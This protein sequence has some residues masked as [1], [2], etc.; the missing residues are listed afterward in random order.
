MRP[1]MFPVVRS[2]GEASGPVS[3]LEVYNGAFGTI[4][5]QGRHGA[6]MAMMSVDH[7]DVL[8]FVRAKEV[9]GT[10][11]NF[12]ISVKMTD[13]FMEKL[14]NH[15]DEPWMCT[16]EGKSVKPRRIL[17]HPNRTVHGVEEVDIT[18]GKLFDEIVEYAWHNGEPGI[19][20]IDEVNRT[21]P[22]P[23]FGDIL[24]SNPC[25]S[26]ET[27]VATKKGLVPI[28]ELARDDVLTDARVP[29]VVTSLAE[30]GSV[31]TAVKTIQGTRG[32]LARAARVWQTGVKPVYRLRTQS[33]Y[34]LV[35]TAD[36]K[37]VTTEGKVELSCL[38]RKHR[39]L[40]QSAEGPFSTARLLP[41][42]VTNEVTGENGRR[43]AYNFPREWSKELG[44]VMGWL[45]GDGWLRDAG[46]PYAAGFTFAEGD[47]RILE[48]LK[49]ILNGFY[50]SEM[51]EIKRPNGVYHL[52]Y[53]SRHFVEFFKALGVRAARSA[54]KRVPESL[55]AAP[56]ET[57]VG[58][59]QGLFSADGTVAND[60]KKGSRY[61]RLTAKSPELL[62]QVQLLLLNLGIKSKLY[63]RARAPREAFAYKSKGG[64]MRR[65]VS[66]GVLYE[67]QIS[68]SSLPIFLEKVG[69]LCGKFD[70][71]VQ[72]VER[73][74]FYREVFE[75][76]V[77]TIE[78]VGERD[79]YDLSEPLTTSFIANGFVI[80]NCG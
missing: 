22:L 62:R 56:R 69:F 50:G 28:K 13:A 31:R 32:G 26:G 4:K 41:F 43:Y 52:T 7:P 72:G 25:V 58:F 36:H 63:D 37:I 20:F 48:Y 57:V 2:E 46:K 79:V 53:G 33:G 34:E 29:D 78:Y 5:Q 23:G 9:E 40:L 17:R 12:N 30:N 21:N 59:L 15:P 24:T 76:R 35:A 54:G 45:V 51:R 14:V 8:D 38:T 61:V 47:L 6:N 71:K 70:E 16:W 68:K 80:S 49:P 60:E 77:D 1:A 73:H 65:Y 55:F 66:D 67:L 75:E 42:L 27:L 10:I 11:A 39:I 18:V 74:G 19:V 44:Q 3:F 64:A